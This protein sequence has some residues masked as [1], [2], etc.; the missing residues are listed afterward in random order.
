M[1]TF[2]FEVL[3]D[4]EKTKILEKAIN[5]LYERYAKKHNNIESSEE[6]LLNSYIKDLLY[7]MLLNESLIELENDNKRIYRYIV[8][9]FEKAYVTVGEF[10]L[11]NNEEDEFI[12]VDN[13][14]EIFANILIETRKYF[15]TV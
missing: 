10:D 3:K 12:F 2:D 4:K 5:G 14:I 7:T 13:C 6:L 11:Q 15:E 8:D 9:K 1:K